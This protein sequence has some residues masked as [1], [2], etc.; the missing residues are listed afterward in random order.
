[1]HT[2]QYGKRDAGTGRLLKKCFYYR[3]CQVAKRCWQAHSCDNGYL[4][5][6][7]HRPFHPEMLNRYHLVPPNCPMRW[8]WYGAVA[9]MHA[10]RDFWLSAKRTPGHFPVE[11]WHQ[12]KSNGRSWH[13]PI[14]LPASKIRA[15]FYPPF[16]S[17]CCKK[18]LSLLSSSRR[19]RRL[20]HRCLVFHRP[21]LLVFYRCM[22]T[23]LS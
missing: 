22:F 8:R 4:P 19:P 17:T 9:C 12:R 21:L 16:Y 2:Y 14:K 6:Q 3:C 5:L 20:C 23:R 7:D 15:V 11:K 1:M 18:H 10:P 13:Q